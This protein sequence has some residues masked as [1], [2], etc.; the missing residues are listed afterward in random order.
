MRAFL[1]KPVEDQEDGGCGI[2]MKTLSCGGSQSS[3]ADGGRLQPK[4]EPTMR[5]LAFRCFALSMTLCILAVL[6]T[7]VAR[8]ADLSFTAIDAE[9][10]SH[11]APDALVLH[12]DWRM[13]ESAIVGDDGKA[14]S[15]AGFDASDWYATSVPTTALG[16]LVQHGVYPDPYI[17]LNNMRIPDASDEHNRRYDLAQYSHLPNEANPW[18]KPYWFRKEFKLP[19]EY[20]GK[21]VWLHLDGVNYRADVWLNGRLVSDAKSIVGM[22]RRFRFDVSSFLSKDGPNALAVCIHPLDFAGDPIHEQ[23]DGPPGSYGPNGGDGEILRNVTQYCSIGWDW[24]AAARDRNMGLWQH[25]WLEATG[26]VAVRDPA[27]MTAVDL[28]SGDKAAVTVR[29]QLDNATSAEQT[30]ELVVRIAPDGFEGAPVELRTRAV[31]PASALTEV[32]LKPEDYSSLVLQ[33]PRLWWPVTYGEQPL[34]QLTVEARVDGQLS[35]QTTR[36]FGVRN[37]GSFVLASGGRAFTVN[38][39]TIRMTGGAWVPDFLSSWSAQ[40]YRD[41]A[42][43]MAEGNHTIVRVNGC[44]IVPPDAF[45]DGCD[46]FGLL[47]W[48]DLSRTSMAGEYRKDGQPKTFEP[49]RCDP[50]VYL[51][52]MKDCIFRLRGRPSLLLWCGCNEAVAQADVGEPLQ[53]EILPTLDGTRPWLPTSHFDPPWGKEPLCV[54]TGGPWHMIRLPEYFRLYAEDP[55]FTCRDEIGLLSPPPINSMAKAIPEIAQPVS[56]WSPWNRAL[57]Y[58]DATGPILRESDKIIRDD[59]GEPACLTEYLWMGDLYSTLSYRAIYEAANKVRPRNSGTHIWKINAAWPSVVQQVFDWYLRPN[60][61]YYGMRSAC[62]PLHAQFSADDQAIQ[63]VS[64]LPETIDNLK[65]RITLVDSNGRI[66]DTQEH[67]V[68]AAADATTPVGS[69]P[70]VAKDGRLHFV[71]LDLLDAE[72]RALDRVVSWVQSDCRFH[73]LMQLP[74]TKIEVR[75]IERG[76]VAGETFYK[77]SVQNTSTVPAVQVWLEVLRGEQGDEVLPSFWSDNALTL[78]PG[79]QR[80]LTVRFRSNLLG[81]TPPDLMAE[82]WNVT[83]REWNIADGKAV[84]LSMEVI[85]SDVQVEGADVKVRFTATQRGPTGA[86]WTTWPVPIKIDGVAARYVRIGLQTG[87]TSSAMATF[88]GL[89]RGEHRIAVGDHPDKTVVVP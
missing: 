34:Y 64:T 24:I 47:V 33:K 71:G 21:T 9:P 16:T 65:V 68:T 42:R 36:R 11:V 87:A 67:A 69:L 76:E 1:K 84:P 15:D 5:S 89:S 45:F 52:N 6:A 8:A 41:E 14:F 29:C 56:E 78:L 2:R 19:T 50:T 54:W 75:V 38:G 70:A 25:V 63:V 22:F 46:R 30:V 26:P 37:V 81:N 53:N 73:E 18:A 49:A 79:E 77:V 39:R 23:L 28:P 82:G 40:R 35:D 85:E 48:Q 60:G 88:A 74:P 61:G 66:E 10:L 13:R 57:G 80:E 17:G 62:R 51:D 83:P 20:Q 4:G 7:T 27:A 72:G 43:L 31:A 59:L 55:M 32:V 44:G 3:V 58:H 12:D 86:R